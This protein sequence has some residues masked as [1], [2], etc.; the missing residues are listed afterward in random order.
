MKTF[1]PTAARKKRE[2][3]ESTRRR[4]LYRRGYGEVLA[5]VTLEGVSPN[6]EAALLRAAVE[7]GT[8]PNDPDFW[9]VIEGALAGIKRAQREGA[10]AQIDRLAGMAE[11]A[12]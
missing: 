11:V 7:A 2:A 4:A 3:R 1:S 10:G 9:P 12:Q 8:I 5:Q 6:D